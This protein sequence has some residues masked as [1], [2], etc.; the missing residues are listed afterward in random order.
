[1]GFVA[2][3]R[4]QVYGQTRP[5]EQVGEQESLSNASNISSFFAWIARQTSTEGHTEPSRHDRAGIS[6]WDSSLRSERKAFLK[7]WGP[8]ADSQ[9][10]GRHAHMNKLVNKNPCP[11]LRTSVPSSYFRQP[12]NLHRLTVG[13]IDLD[14]PGA[15]ANGETAVLGVVNR[16]VSPLVDVDASRLSARGRTDIELCIVESDEAKG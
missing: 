14:T 9:Y 15:N 5:H 13:L 2:S 10:M 8:P 4:A 11:T 6:L 7:S 3:E 16:L 12:Q 1:V